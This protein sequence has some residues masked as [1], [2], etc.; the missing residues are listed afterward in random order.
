MDGSW[1]EPNFI[2]SSQENPNPLLLN[3]ELDL[4]DSEESPKQTHHWIGVLDLGMWKNL[5]WFL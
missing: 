5:I 3:E 1:G 2:Y 4:V